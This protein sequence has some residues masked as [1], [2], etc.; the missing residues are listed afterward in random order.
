[1]K[2]PPRVVAVI[3]FAGALPLAAEFTAYNDIAAGPTTHANTTTYAPNAT[4]SG[5]APPP[6][7][8]L[9]PLRNPA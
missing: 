1:M 8:G 2:S 5:A 7:P 6:S 4:A 9:Q 3:I